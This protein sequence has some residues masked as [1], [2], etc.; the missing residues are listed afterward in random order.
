MTVNWLKRCSP[1][2]EIYSASSPTG[3]IY[4]RDERY[5]TRLYR[6]ASMGNEL[7]AA[8]T[9]QSSHPGMNGQHWP[10]QPGD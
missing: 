2:R 10:A 3:S 1:G 8:L 7:D 4:L 6:T 9:I 5:L